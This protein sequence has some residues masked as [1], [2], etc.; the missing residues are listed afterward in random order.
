M[1]FCKFALLPPLSVAPF[2]LPTAHPI[3]PVHRH[4]FH[5]Y[6]SVTLLLQILFS[7][8]LQ[9]RVLRFGCGG[10]KTNVLFCCGGRYGSKPFGCCILN[11]RLTRQFRSVH[12]WMS[13]RRFRNSA[14]CI[15]RLWFLFPFD[16]MLSCL[17]LSNVR[18]I[19][20][21][22]FIWNVFNLV[23]IYTNSGNG[24]IVHQW[25]LS[26]DYWKVDPGA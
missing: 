26:R 7:Q 2:T 14:D 13:C 1:F 16:V 25:S 9:T 6:S 19:A 18:V 22:L 3:L 5:C 8:W 24:W 10:A 12:S 21:F 20:F 4:T 11:R 23:L 15:H 17:L